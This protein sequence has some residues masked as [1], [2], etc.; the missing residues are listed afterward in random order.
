MSSKLTI[1]YVIRFEKSWFPCTIINTNFKLFEEMY[2]GKE[3]KQL[4]AISHNSVG[5]HGLSID[6]FLN[7]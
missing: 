5:I 2:L 1:L 4:H 6:Q 3:N 7:G